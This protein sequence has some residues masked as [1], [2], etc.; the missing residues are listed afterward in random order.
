MYLCNRRFNRLIAF[1]V[2]INNKVVMSFRNRTRRPE[3]SRY[4][5]GSHFTIYHGDFRTCCNSCTHTILGDKASLHLEGKG[6]GIA[7][8]IGRYRNAIPNVTKTVNTIFHINGYVVQ[9]IR[10]GDKRCIMGLICRYIVRR[11]ETKEEVILLSV[12]TELN[13]RNV[14]VLRVCN[15]Q[16]YVTCGHCVRNF[17]F[18][19]RPY[20][21]ITCLERHVRQR[22]IR[23]FRVLFRLINTA[24]FVQIGQRVFSFRQRERTIRGQID[25]ARYR[26][27]EIVQFTVQEPVI[28]IA[29]IFVIRF[30]FAQ[31]RRISN[32]LV[33]RYVGKVGT[34][35]GYFVCIVKCPVYR[36]RCVG[37]IIG[38]AKIC[39]IQNLYGICHIRITQIII[40]REFATL[41]KQ[42]L[43]Y[44]R[45]VVCSIDVN[46]HRTARFTP[47]VKIVGKL[48][49]FGVVVKDATKRY[50]GI[51][52]LYVQF[53]FTKEVASKHFTPIRTRM[54]VRT[55]C[56]RYLRR[57]AVRATFTFYPVI[58]CAKTDIDSTTKVQF[59][60][61][62]G[63][64][65]VTIRVVTNRI[66]RGIMRAPERSRNLGHLLRT[67]KHRDFRACINSCADAHVRLIF[68]F[69]LEYQ[70]M[71]F[72]PN[73]ST[74]AFTRP[75]FTQRCRTI[76]EI[77]VYLIQKVG[78]G[79]HRRI[80]PLV[81]LRIIR[82]P[83]HTKEEEILIPTGTELYLRDI[84]GK[85]NLF[86]IFQL[87]GYVICRHRG[88]RF[89][90][91]HRP[92]TFIPCFFRDC[93]QSNRFALFI[94]LR[95]I[96]A[97]IFVQIGNFV[98]FFNSPIYRPRCIG[99]II[100]G[101][102][103]FRIQNLYG[104]C[105]ICIAQIIIAREFATFFKQD[106]INGRTVVCSV[107]IHLHRTA[108][109]TPVVIIESKLT[110]FGV[111]VK[112]TTKRYPSIRFLYMQFHFTK[113]V[114]GKHLT[115]IRTRMCV[116]TICT[117]YLRRKAVRSTFTF[118]PVVAFAKT[119]I[120]HT[121]K[122]YFCQGRGNHVV[123]VRVIANSII[124][125]IMRTPERSRNRGNFLRAVE[126]RD[127]R[128][129]INSCTST[130]IRLIFR[131]HGEY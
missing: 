61:R 95:G 51:R 12:A 120:D 50:P 8:T 57:K 113:E 87:Q 65:V 127:F 2:M 13:L 70:R 122:M 80:M 114:A 18:F 85:N 36:P 91:F 15:L 64:H 55:I 98:E 30:R 81:K 16:G 28:G 121:A 39:F 59:C 66:I 123:T 97:T 53:H 89:A 35:K 62:R 29:T 25:V 6:I 40:A 75:S 20:A 77:K 43:I 21:F 69:H 105:H 48:T 41:F 46:L 47:V 68:R 56:T 71:A 99:H 111:V 72:T 131:F 108:R 17:A 82:Q 107:N 118:H 100:R 3:G 63:N 109:F 4:V 32:R 74:A 83:I 84:V 26:G 124:R 102:K 130:H 9:Q 101:A 86:R 31:C 104:I 7:P 110:S 67:I 92:C 117:R 103:I 128:A 34:V 93:G 106:L 45:T 49:S 1:N 88:R 96:N 52:F 94:F 76:Q 14:K 19:H 22:N 37:H 38:G 23:I 112:D 33:S 119:D 73:V 116:R 54:C 42:D 126:H 27:R 60:Q 79:N 58:A 125:S 10:V 5:R 44:S 115:P 11:V 90:T 24:V 129:S 78:A